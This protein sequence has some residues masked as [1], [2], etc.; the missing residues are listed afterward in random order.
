MLRDTLQNYNCSIAFER[1]VRSDP[2]AS[3]FVDTSIFRETCL[4]WEKSLTNLKWAITFQVQRIN[5]FTLGLA[6]ALR[7]I[8]VIRLIHYVGA[9]RT[10]VPL[11]VRLFRWDL[12]TIDW[13]EDNNDSMHS[14]E[15]STAIL[16]RYDVV[17]VM[18]SSIW[19]WLFWY[20]SLQKWH[21]EHEYLVEMLK[22]VTILPWKIQILNPLL[23]VGCPFDFQPPKTKVC[24]YEHSSF[25]IL[26]LGTSLLGHLGSASLSDQTWANSVVSNWFL[27]HPIHGK[28]EEGNVS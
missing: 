3:I 18:L 21:E 1:T 17:P 15:R 14:D 20:F 22:E 25:F 28:A 8:R 27:G 6:R 16:I 10:L 7:G 13:N 24:N 19:I 12:K 11:G 23:D 26:D 5:S 2:W 9:L 4:A